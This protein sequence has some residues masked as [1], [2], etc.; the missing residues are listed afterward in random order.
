MRIPFFAAGLVA[1]TLASSAASACD[2]CGGSTQYLQAGVGYYDIINGKDTA[3][4]GSLEYQ[5]HD[6]YNG[7][8]QVTGILV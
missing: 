4:S 7:L 2:V 8:R 6:V 1:L 5:Y 3:A